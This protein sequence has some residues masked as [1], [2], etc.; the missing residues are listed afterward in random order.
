MSH[1]SVHPKTKSRQQSPKKMAHSVIKGQK[2]SRRPEGD[3]MLR[4][5][6]GAWGLPNVVTTVALNTTGVA[7]KQWHSLMP[8]GANLGLVLIS[9]MDP[10]VAGKF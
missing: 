1:V 2:P 7:G 6:Q 8:L 9:S 3:A 10:E 5:L 4:G